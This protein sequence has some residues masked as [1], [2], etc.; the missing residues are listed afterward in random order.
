MNVNGSFLGSSG[1]GGIGGVFR[2]SEGKVFVQF[3]KEVSTDLIVLAE[4]LSL[5][6]GILVAVASRWNSS[7]SFLFVSD[8]KLVVV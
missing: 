7:H 4:V 5:K 3:S 8:S 6:Q 1:R 2:D